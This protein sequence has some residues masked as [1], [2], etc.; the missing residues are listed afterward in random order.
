[1]MEN[2]SI[3]LLNEG[4]ANSMG[5][6]ANEQVARATTAALARVFNCPPRDLPSRM[7]DTGEIDSLLGLEILMS[8]EA[9]FGITI[10]DDQLSS[11]LCSSIPRLTDLVSGKLAEA[12]SQEGIDD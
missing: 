10:N 11:R 2:P 5:H 12:N 8:L 6:P 1:M 7:T 3:D 4:N 9:Q